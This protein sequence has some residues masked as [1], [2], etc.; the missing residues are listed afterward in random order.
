[1]EAYS[2]FSGKVRS[3]VRLISRT[4]RLPLPGD[5]LVS[6]GDQVQPDTVVARIALRPG[7]PRV[8]PVAGHLGIPPAE[9]SSRM[10][11]AV[12][13]R[14][15]TQEVIAVVDRG[16]SGRK[17]Y[18]SPADGVIE[19]ISDLSGRVVIR[20]EFGREDPPVPVDVASEL[21]CRPSEIPQHM[22]RQVGQEVLQGQMIAK[23]GEA[24]AFFTKTAIAPISGIISEINGQT[25]K[26]T[27]SR[28]FKQVEVDAY[29][30]GRVTEVLPG[31]GCVVQTPG[32]RLNGIFGVGKETCGEIRVVTGGPDETLTAEM[33]VPE[34]A[35]KVVVGGSFATNEALSK[36]LETGVKAVV[37]GTV[38]Y[39]N[40]TASLGVKLG[41]GIT[42]QEATGMTVVLMEGFGHLSM[43]REVWDVLKALE[44]LPAS[45][46]GATQIRAGAIRPEVV[47]PLPLYSGP[48]GDDEPVDEDLRAGLR[49]RVVSQPHFGAIGTVTHI[50]KEPE[51]VETEAMV[52]VVR[53]LLQDGREVS[54]PRANVEVY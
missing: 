1:M 21:R 50:V 33:I 54:I 44:G 34:L 51:A 45:V 38:N 16:L 42:G 40:L 47:V 13:D 35:G 41:V 36:A 6:V 20:E 27:I 29:I 48:I 3:M 8:I 46:N 18:G 30:S 39:L 43:R 23:K 2:G 52:P 14:V 37:T 22:L 32:I 5:V 10:V 25:G 17:E 26:V 53:V 7:I 49:V 12:G 11:K 24:Q 4:R 31:Q 9:L 19:E 28:P 15:K